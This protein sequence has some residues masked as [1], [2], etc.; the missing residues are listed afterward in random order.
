M[1]KTTCQQC[2][3]EFLVKEYKIKKSEGKYCSHAC[4]GE[5]QR[6]KL[7][8]TCLVCGKEFRVLPSKPNHKYCSLECSFKNRPKKERTEYK[9]PT[10][11]NLF[12]DRPNVRTGKTAYCSK[13]CY[14]KSQIGKPSNLVGKKWDHAHPCKGKWKLKEKA[15]ELCGKIVTGRSWVINQT[16]KYKHHYCSKKCAG[17]AQRKDD[18]VCPRGYGR[19]EYKEWKIAILARDGG[20]CRL[21]EDEGTVNR[22]RLQIHHIIPYSIRPDLEFNTDNGIAL[23]KKHHDLMRNKEDE[24]A[25]QLAKLIGK[26]LLSIPKPNSHVLRGKYDNHTGDKL[27]HC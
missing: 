22:K 11:G 3:K 20:K 14:T 23:C 6:T 17:L 21:C 25:E 19:T 26:P 8:S 9:C 15:C 16:S 12:Y 5:A 10:C 27:V 18:K 1:I 4:V 24:W 2:G 7:S 13:E